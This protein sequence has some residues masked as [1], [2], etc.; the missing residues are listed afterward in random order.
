MKQAL[1][2]H[3]D[4]LAKDAPALHRAAQQL[5]SHHGGTLPADT[6]SLEKLP[7]IGRYTAG[8]IASIAFGKP[9]PVVDGNVARVLS[10]IWAIDDPLSSGPG[11]KR[12]WNLATML[13]NGNNPGD[14]NQA[15][16]EVGALVCTPTTPACERCPARA[17][18]QAHAMGKPAAFPVAEQGRPRQQL[19]VAFAWTRTRRGIWLVQRPL[20]GLWA[21][22]WELPSAEGPAARRDLAHRLER[23]LGVC[24]AEVAHQLT[25]R[26]VT[27]RVYALPQL[28]RFQSRSGIRQ[29]ADPFVAPLSGLAKKAIQAALKSP[30]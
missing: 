2:V 6:N 24:I 21:G 17:E 5:V 8:A 25:H 18:C 30:C 12:L 7:G 29:Y 4:L 1:L 27:A 14:L 22:Q 15:L 13:A 11:K 19:D 26:D 16:M 28:P 23:K 9:A 20:N 10:R 3:R